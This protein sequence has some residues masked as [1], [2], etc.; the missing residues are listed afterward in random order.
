[1]AQK[2]TAFVVV[3]KSWHDLT[4]TPLISGRESS[5]KEDAHVLIGPVHDLSDA[6]G[7][8]LSDFTS[9]VFRKDGTVVHMNVLIPW[10]H[11]L[12]VGVADES[13]PSPTGFKGGTVGATENK[14]E[15]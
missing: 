7:L 11:V 14:R 8:W 4:I 5:S 10:Q 3:T 6:R 1:M 9:N 12:F 2:Q 15:D 13:I